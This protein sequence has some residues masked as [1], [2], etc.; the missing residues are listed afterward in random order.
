M[1]KTVIFLLAAVLLVWSAP[2]AKAQ[3][4]KRVSVE[5][6]NELLQKVAGN[7][8]VDFSLW[9]PQTKEF[10]TSSGD[11]S[12]SKQQQATYVR[13]QFKITKPDGSIEEGEGFLSYSE[14]NKRFE[15]VQIDN[16]GKSTLLLTGEWYPENNTLLLTPESGLEKWGSRNGTPMQLQYI[17]FEDGTFMKAIRTPD[18]K[19]NYTLFSQY[20]YKARS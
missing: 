3:K 5:E 11:A 15:F 19:G 10:L 13:E 8:Q 9:Q 7:W 16:T 14:K 6:A 4:A 20:H 2:I 1:K 12:F 18:G 17:F